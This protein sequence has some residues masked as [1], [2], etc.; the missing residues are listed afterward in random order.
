MLVQVHLQESLSPADVTN[1]HLEI[2]PL[3]LP[4]SSLKKIKSHIETAHDR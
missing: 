3:L 2:A 1:N 4:G